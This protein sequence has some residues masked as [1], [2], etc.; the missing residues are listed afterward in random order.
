MEKR[1]LQFFGK[2]QH[3]LIDRRRQDVRDQAKEMAEAASMLIF[4]NCLKMYLKIMNFILCLEPSS[5]RR[6]AEYD[7]QVR[8]AAEREGRRTRRRCERERQDMLSSHL[9]GMSSDE[10]TSDRYQE[11]FQNELGWFEFDLL[12]APLPKIFCFSTSFL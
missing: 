1:C 9:D 2:H 11:L 12:F 7:E 6:G 8:R 10:E 4:E 3:F 5:I